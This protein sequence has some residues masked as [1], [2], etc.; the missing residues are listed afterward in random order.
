M[1][2]V[3]LLFWYKSRRCLRDTFTDNWMVNLAKEILRS[4]IIKGATFEEIQL[5]SRRS[6]QLASLQLSNQIQELFRAPDTAFVKS[7]F[8]ITSNK[9]TLSQTGILVMRCFRPRNIQGITLAA[10]I[11]FYEIPFVPFIGLVDT[12][13]DVSRRWVITLAYQLMESIPELETPVLKALHSTGYN[14]ENQIQ[15]LIIGPLLSLS[16]EGQLLTRSEIMLVYLDCIDCSMNAPSL[17]VD[18]A[19]LI[20]KLQSLRELRFRFLVTGTPQRHVQSIFQNVP[21]EI[22]DLQRPERN[23]QYV[24]GGIQPPSE[25][26]PLTRV[27]FVIADSQQ[28]S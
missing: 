27:Y 9:D 1:P 23:S 28:C 17:I 12:R 18:I 15:A 26:S 25:P 10:H 7:Q 13:P 21:I 19:Y 6:R 2:T 11:L 22:S 16:A 8:L 3:F 24:P 14:S 5:A 20:D 4:S